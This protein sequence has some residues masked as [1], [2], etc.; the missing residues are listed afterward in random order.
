MKQSRKALKETKQPARPDAVAFLDDLFGHEADWT[1]LVERARVNR[2]V[3]HAIHDLRT[4]HGLT[5]Q[6][7]AELIGSRQSVIARLEDADYQS[8]SL[9]MLS[10]I[11][12]ALHQR[13]KV[14]FVPLAESAAEPRSGCSVA[15][16][17]GRQST[18]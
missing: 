13:V 4:S 3:A 5:Q 11:A 8:H 18:G 12:T 6:Q 2:D 9:T 16:K 17:T 15:A 7:L 10:R 1:P 14:E